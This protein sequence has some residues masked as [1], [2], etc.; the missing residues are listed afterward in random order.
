MDHCSRCGARLYGAMKFCGECGTP[1]K[2]TPASQRERSRDDLPGHTPWEQKQREEPAEKEIPGFTPAV[3]TRARGQCPL[4][5]NPA[6]HACFFC[7]RDFCKP[8]LGRLQANTMP[9]YQWD[10]IPGGATDADMREGWRGTMV[11]SCR[12]CFGDKTHAELTENEKSKLGTVDRATWYVIE[13][14]QS[15]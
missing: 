8:H 1:Q 3:N 10:R 15:A 9:I 11:H 5:G 14:P 4:C 13:R 6:A 2:Q 7:G 12:R